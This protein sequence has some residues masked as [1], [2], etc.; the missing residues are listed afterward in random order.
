MSANP[1]PGGSPSDGATIWVG[2]S[3][4]GAATSTVVPCAGGAPGVVT[5][6]WNSAPLPNVDAAGTGSELT[7]P[8]CGAPVAGCPLSG[9]PGCQAGSVVGE[10]KGDGVTWLA[11]SSD[12][13]PAPNGDGE[14]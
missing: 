6:G 14:S 7:G 5:P 13:A 1:G 9:S 4:P 10:E 11:A 8:T 2:S 12:G 3:I